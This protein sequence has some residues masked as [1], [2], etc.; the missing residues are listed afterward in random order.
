MFVSLPVHFNFIAVGIV[1]KFYTNLCKW[2]S[3]QTHTFSFPAFNNNNLADAQVCE[4]GVALA[5]F[6]IRS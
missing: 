2:M 3:P 1:I 6:N 4:V 5:P